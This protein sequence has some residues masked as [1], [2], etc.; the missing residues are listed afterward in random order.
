[1]FF[2]CWR[3]RAVGVEFKPSRPDK[4]GGKD[5]GCCGSESAAQKSGKILV[6]RGDHRKSRWSEAPPLMPWDVGDGG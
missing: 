3:M 2:G 5:W 1:M 6:P 4:V